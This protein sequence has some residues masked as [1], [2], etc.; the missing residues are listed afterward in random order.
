MNT[1]AV[2]I[3]CFKVKSHIF[4][5]L[6]KIGPKVAAIYVVDDACP[7]NTGKHVQEL[8]RDARVRVLFHQENQ[9][10][11]GAMIAGY[12]AALSDGHSILVKIDGD[13]QMDPTLIEQ[14]VEPILSGEADYTKGNRFFNLENIRSMP[15]IRL[16]GNSLLSFVT[17]ISSGYWD[18]FDPANGYTAIHRDVASRL[19]FQK[20]SKRYFFES[21]MLFRLNV[22]RAVVEDIPMDAKYGDE[23]SN[24]KIHKVF[25]EFL[26]KHSVNF[27]RRIFYNY[28]LRDMSVASFELPFGVLLFSFG[29]IFGLHNWY[30]ASIGGPATTAGTVM[31]SALPIIGGF[32]L[33]LAFLAYDIASVPK[34][35]LHTRL[36]DRLSMK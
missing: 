17:K 5:V 11:G 7:Q 24:L 16:I 29:T 23:I 34:L 30:L 10:V 8:V 21:D 9:G 20:I 18:I 6:E 19:P 14:F 12:Q 15:K 2:V 4:E 22:I 25:F 31:L 3:P 27:L 36:A 13:G 35:V 33:I 32:Q 26:Y 28:Y 1:I